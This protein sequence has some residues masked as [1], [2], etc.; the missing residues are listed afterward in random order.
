[1]P[2]ST[3][4]AVISLL[5][6]VLIAL[7]TATL[8]SP[9]HAAPGRQSM[10]QCVDRVLSRLARARADEAQVGPTLLF[11]CDGPS[12]APG[13]GAIG[14]GRPPLATAES[15]RAMAG[16]GASDEATAEYRQRFL[17]R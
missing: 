11:P 9:A 10:E 1:M 7:T 15:C 16:S 3:C 2:R 14:R 17:R 8:P 5:S 6:A 12:A 4:R 13:G